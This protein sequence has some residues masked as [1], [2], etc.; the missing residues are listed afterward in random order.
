MSLFLRVHRG[1]ERDKLR[2]SYLPTTYST[3]PNLTYPPVLSRCLPGFPAIV[4]RRSQLARRRMSSWRQQVAA[5]TR[6]VRQCLC[7][8]YRP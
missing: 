4:N 7:P 6:H 8:T 1:M 5:Q 2:P 3:L